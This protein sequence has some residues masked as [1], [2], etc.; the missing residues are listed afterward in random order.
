MIDITKV[1]LVQFV[2]KVYDLSVP[3]GFGFLHAVDGSLT[4]EEASTLINPKGRNAISMDY[5]RGRACKMNVFR[6]DDK[7]TI[8]DSWYDHTDEDFNVLL[9]TFNINRPELA[10]HGCSCACSTCKV[11]F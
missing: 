3:Q 4:D 7:L 9:D 5:V 1:D 6:T 2:K 10:E 8:N 11:S